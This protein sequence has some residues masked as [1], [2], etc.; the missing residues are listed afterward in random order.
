MGGFWGNSFQIL[1]FQIRGVLY[2]QKILGKV[3]PQETVYFFPSE[4]PKFI[5]LRYISSLRPG[6]DNLFVPETFINGTVCL[7]H[8]S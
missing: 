7:K 4:F 5:R 1:L 6:L 2:K 8:C 3:Q